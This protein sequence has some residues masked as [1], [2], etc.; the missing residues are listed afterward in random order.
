MVLLGSESDQMPRFLSRNAGNR[1]LSSP[2]GAPF[3]SVAEVA[4]LDGARTMRRP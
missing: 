1:A 4:V 3:A 2:I